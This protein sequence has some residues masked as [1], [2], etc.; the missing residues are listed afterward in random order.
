LNHSTHNMSIQR[1]FLLALCCLYPCTM[2]KAAFLR[3]ALPIVVINT[4]EFRREIRH[5]VVA[6]ADGREE[7]VRQRRVHITKSLLPIWQALPHDDNGKVGPRAFRYLTNRYFM[8]RSSIVLRGFEL[9]V[10]ANHTTWSEED[11]LSENL[12]ETLMSTMIARNKGQRG[13]GLSDIVDMV[14]MLETLV[15]DSDDKLLEHIYEERGVGFDTVTRDELMSVLESY[16]LHWLVEDDDRVV[17]IFLQ[18]RTLL[19]NSFPHWYDLLEL[20]RGQ[21]AAFDFV[22]LRC[23]GRISGNALAMKYSFRDV[24]EIVEGLTS[25]FASFWQS[26]C[27]AM[28]DHLVNLDHR[29][30]GRVPLLHFYRAAAAGGNGAHFSES[31]LYLWLHGIIDSE[32]VMIGP[33]VII[34]N[35]IQSPSNCMVNMGHYLVCCPNE[36][37]AVQSELEHELNAPDASPDE[38]LQALTNINYLV[39]FDTDK[40][41]LV[42]VTRQLESY[43]RAM[44]DTYNG[45]V[46]VYG[47]LFSQ[48]LHYVFPRECAFPHRSNQAVAVTAGAFGSDARLN[49]SELERRA[50]MTANEREINAVARFTRERIGWIDMWDSE[51]EWFV[52]LGIDMEQL[53]PDVDAG[54]TEFLVVLVC[55]APLP[56]LVLLWAW[57]CHRW[58]WCCQP[59]KKVSYMI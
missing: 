29:H 38:I 17:M 26:E 54:I 44:G 15:V 55:L 34:P 6:V 52:D 40:V 37:E 33:Q 27:A 25:S 3:P 50:V 16:I 35:Y 59:Q 42:L 41:P 10:P 12:P 11:I 31:E 20:L 23:P 56:L 46:P 53:S 1:S 5:A 13:F 22:R 58:G 19:E 45:S 28:K 57:C 9:M 48:W 49:T 30:A 24:R 7:A 4:S 32:G 36:C 14:M 43:L 39:T 21:V 2:V 8:R 47:R 51:E 18:N